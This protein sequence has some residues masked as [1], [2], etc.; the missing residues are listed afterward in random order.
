MESRNSCAQIRTA[1]RLYFIYRLFP[2]CFANQ[3]A[4]TNTMIYLSLK[5][6][7]ILEKYTVGQGSRT[8]LGLW[9]V[10]YI[11]ILTSGIDQYLQR[12]LSAFIK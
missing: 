5:P 11:K 7:K 3:N 6:P 10:K 4:K 12:E 8:A 9:W 1:K 2:W